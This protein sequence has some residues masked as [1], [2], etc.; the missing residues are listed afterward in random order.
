MSRDL[1]EWQATTLALAHRTASVP[2][3]MDALWEIVL[4]INSEAACFDDEAAVQ[5]AVRRTI[6]R[7]DCILTESLASPLN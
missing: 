3:T 7:A 5:H 1:L 4:G 2:L 6:K